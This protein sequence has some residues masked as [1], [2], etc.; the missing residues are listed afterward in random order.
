MKLRSFES[1]KTRAA[2]H[3]VLTALLLCGVAFC[4]VK[5]YYDFRG[6]AGSLL[7]RLMA[8]LT[9]AIAFV[10]VSAVWFVN[11]ISVNVKYSRIRRIYGGYFGGFL[12]RILLMLELAGFALFI[13]FLFI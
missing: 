1:M 6:A 11:W 4:Y 9:W 7:D 10:A 2:V 12:G 13:V 5:L 3:F 8:N